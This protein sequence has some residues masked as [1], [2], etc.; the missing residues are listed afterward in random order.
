MACP[1]GRIFF[2]EIEGNW[3]RLS[4]AGSPQLSLSLVSFSIRL[5]SN[6]DTCFRMRESHNHKQ[7]L[8]LL[9]READHVLLKMEDIPIIHP[10]S[11]R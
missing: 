8:R 11:S 9:F 2:R 1:L 7:I 5:E 3:L 10:R 4:L 6:V